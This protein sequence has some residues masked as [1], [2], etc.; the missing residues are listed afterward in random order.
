MAYQPVS[1]KMY[2]QMNRKIASFSHATVKTVQAA[3]LVIKLR[4][5]ITNK[6][7]LAQYMHC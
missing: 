6:K 3:K 2:F 4:G 1:P 5:N 7:A